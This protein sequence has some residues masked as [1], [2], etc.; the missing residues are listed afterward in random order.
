MPLRSNVFGAFLPYIR[1]AMTFL[2][3][4]LM[5]NPNF[6]FSG[7]YLVLFCCNLKNWDK[8]LT[9]RDFLSSQCGP[10]EGPIDFSFTYHTEKGYE[11]KQQKNQVRVKCTFYSRLKIV[12][13]N[14]QKTVLFRSPL[15]E[16][17]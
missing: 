14:G 7:P 2:D 4:N 5:Q 9:G 10:S 12:S 11:I 16:K 3:R 13:K 1:S 6:M 8:I 17:L 15:F